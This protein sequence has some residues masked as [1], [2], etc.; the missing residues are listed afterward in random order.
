M[1]SGTRHVDQIGL[2]F[3]ET[4]LPLPPERGHCVQKNPTLEGFSKR[5][6]ATKCGKAGD[7]F[8]R[9]WGVE[10]VGIY[11]PFLLHKAGIIKAPI[12][13]DGWDRIK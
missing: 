11:F 7:L 3:T 5:A 4:H 10:L 6:R 12:L 8:R 1:E 13:W 9:W 2:K